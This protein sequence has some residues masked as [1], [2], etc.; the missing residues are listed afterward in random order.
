MIKVGSL[1]V[2]EVRRCLQEVVS[3]METAEQ[4]IAGYQPGQLTVDAG[5][6]FDSE[7]NEVLTSF[8]IRRRKQADAYD[9]LK[10]LLT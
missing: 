10:S 2:T 8:Q 4:E 9:R 3:A 7:G 6:H 1:T 5:K